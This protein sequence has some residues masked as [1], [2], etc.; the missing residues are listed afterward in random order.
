MSMRTPTVYIETSVFNFVFADDAPERRRHT[1]A[2]FEEIR[3]GRYVPYTSEYVF[4]EL[5]R[6]PSPKREK[7]LALIGEYHVTVLPFSEEAERLAD[8]YVAERIIPAR[9]L[10]DA[11]HIAVASVQ[12]LA[13]I[14]SFN[15]QHIVKR[16][17]VLMTEMVNL[18]E[19]YKRIGIYSPTEVIEHVE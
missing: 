16:N 1:L 10:T 17:T 11:H 18:R 19:G 12:D 2:F 7:M 14:V 5:E 3:Q 9:Y 15:F 8:M 13:F 6:A 4:R